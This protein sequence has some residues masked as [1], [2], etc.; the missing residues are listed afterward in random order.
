MTNPVI[1]QGERL[2]EAAVNCLDGTRQYLHV[3]VGPPNEV[4]G[5][6]WELSVGLIAET[7]TYGSA[8]IGRNDI[9]WQVTISR[10]CDFWQIAEGGDGLG[11]T[12]MINSA[13]VLASAYAEQVQDWWDIFSGI[14][15]KLRELCG[16]PCNDVLVTG[17]NPPARN[18]LCIIGTIQV[19]MQI[20]LD[21]SCCD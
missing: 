1:R 2:L 14:K 21:S 17:A 19:S 5:V 6:C 20:G 16:D 3:Y 4:A 11:Q 18:G 8:S 10:C 12:I 15:G 13:E 9:Q 7:A